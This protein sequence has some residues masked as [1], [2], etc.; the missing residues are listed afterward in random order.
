[1][2]ACTCGYSEYLLVEAVLGASHSV[3]TVVNSKR[4]CVLAWPRKNERTALK[5]QETSEYT[6]QVLKANLQA[7]FVQ[8]A[9]THVMLSFL[10]LGFPN[11]Q[12]Q[13]Q[14]HRLRNCTLQ[15]HS[16]QCR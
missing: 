3:Q 11:H 14:A 9:P 4:S 7:P 10:F 6:A 2:F 15:L 12:W 5:N 1:M 8:R 16:Q 13:P